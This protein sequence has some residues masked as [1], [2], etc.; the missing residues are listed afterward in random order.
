M[1]PGTNIILENNLEAVAGLSAPRILDFN[2]IEDPEP[3]GLCALCRTIDLN[4]DS[5]LIPQRD[6]DWDG[7]RKTALSEEV[8]GWSEWKAL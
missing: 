6:R 3:E 7:L 1:Q 2:H 5:F 8:D 4:I